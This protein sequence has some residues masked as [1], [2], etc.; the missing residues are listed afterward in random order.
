MKQEEFESY[1]KAGKIANKIR[2][3]MKNFIKQ[4][5]KLIEIAE[6]IDKKIEEANAKPAFPVNLSLNEIAAHYTPSKE[7][8]N[9]AEGLL[10][11]DFGVEINGYIADLAF[12][13]D[14][15]ED[16]K[17]KE[18]IELNHK[19]LDETIKKL[20]TNSS[21]CDIG[22]NITELLKNSKYNIISNLTGHSLEKYT[23]HGEISIPN[24]PNQDQ[25][26][27]N[28]KAIAIEP[29]LTTGTGEVIEGKPSEIF[30]LI[31]KKNVRD[32]ESRKIIS[33]IEENYKTKPFC[34]RWLDKEG[35]RTNFSLKLLVKEGILYNFPVLVEKSK[36]PVS[37]AEET[38]VFKD[39]KTKVITRS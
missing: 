2:E 19:I 24:I 27:L 28:N 37:Q 38:I 22:N 16:K 4:G 39:N 31:N 34:K 11:I 32:P 25:T 17:Y 18:M 12:S 29:F 10:T 5:M 3:E 35:F 36:K 7:D 6:E 14:L 1:C 30:M 15:T 8:G 33:F 23:I 13:I 21:V 26:K 9:I 20:D